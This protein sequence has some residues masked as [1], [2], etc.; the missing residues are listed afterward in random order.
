MEKK[1]INSEEYKLVLKFANNI[2]SNI[3]KAPIDKI[4]DFQNIDRLDIIADNNTTMLN[5]MEP[6]IYTYFDKVKCGYYRKTNTYILNCFRSMVKQIGYKMEYKKRD[7]GETIN[8]KYYRS[9]H[10]YYYI[11]E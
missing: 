3:G 10:L 7:K 1:D 4:T 11:N 9:K 5:D 2:L 6:E 8:N